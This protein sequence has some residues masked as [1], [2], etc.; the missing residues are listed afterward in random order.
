MGLKNRMICLF[1]AAGLVPIV[2]IG[3]L[4]SVI[5]TNGLMDTSYGQLVSMRGIK[6]VQIENFFAERKGDM[7][8]LVET[9]GT[10][11]QEAMNKLR[12]IRTI[13]KNQIEGFFNER[14]G[15]VAVLAKSGDVGRI[16]RA[17]QQYQVDTGVTAS[18]TYDVSTAA[19]KSLWRNN[20]KFLNYYVEAYGYYDMFI[21]SPQ[22]HVMYTTAKESDLGTNLRYGQLKD[23]GLAQLWKKVVETDKVAI[24]D[25]EPYAPSNNEPA[26][27]IGAPIKSGGRIVGVVALQ[28]SL[29]AINSIM[30]ERTGLGETGET[31]LVGSDFLMRSDSFLDP[32]HHTVKASFADPVKGKADTEAVQF[33]LSGK[34]GEDVI[35]DYNG[36]PVL[37][38]F[39]PVNVPGLK[40]AVLS[41]IDV[42]EAFSP[43]S[44]EGEEFFKKYQELYDYY[45]LFLINPNGYVF[46]TA[47]R[48]P[49]YQ[50]NMVDGKYS[51]SNLG[52]LTRDV[53][54]SKQFGFADFAPYAPSKGAPA[55]FIAQP[56][57]HDGETE[58]V[59]ALQLSLA[60]ING[61]MQQ[62]EGMG[63]TGETYLV[64]PDKLMRSDSFLDPSGHTVEASFAG[65]VQNNGVD[66]EAARDALSGETDTK[67]IIDYNGNPVLSAFTPLNVF[68]TT[69]VLI[70]EIDE[71]EVEA[72]VNRLQWLIGFIA[73]VMV[74]G[75]VAIALI[76]SSRLLK[77]L[78]NEPE[79]IAEIATQVSNGDLDIE[80]RDDGKEIV[81]VYKTMKIMAEK[82]RDVVTEVRK[83]S[84]NMASGSEELSSSSQALSQGATEQ[85]ASVEEVSSSV[86]EM[87]SSIRQNADNSR[88]TEQIAGQASS[89]ASQGGEAVGQTVKAMKQIAE[90]ISVI[91]EI[92]RQTNLLALNA[93]IEA[94][95][96]GEH[97]K[98]FAVVAAEVRKLAEKS[99]EAASEI[100]E[101]SASS[102]DVAEKAGEL[103]GKMVPDIQKTSELIHEISAA[104]NEQDTGATQI[105]SAIQQLDGVIQQNASGSEEVASTAEELSSQAMQLMQSISFFKVN[106][107]T[108]YTSN[109]QAFRTPAAPLPGTDEEWDEEA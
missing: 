43:K 53:L 86:E 88:K 98:G 81:G 8:V 104:S 54:K 38:A 27:F 39:A 48:E 22:G 82:L 94:A 72:P 14:F 91:E 73:L 77:Q 5:S 21:I 108:I 61:I 57:I 40:W 11:R 75:V 64:G 6:K 79:V 36:N 109:V 55:A 52:K 37:S 95:R 20:S 2:L 96:A 18:G 90:K 56:V 66:T 100:S 1:L 74:A 50:T 29:D 69:W 59:I 3:V 99:G 31:Y 106:L 62:R 92:A 24:Q 71:A 46:Y 32:K 47:T 85:A 78:G 19:Y 49:D 84:E 33:A 4:A 60:A 10:L 97:G 12:A 44:V 16:L 17:L 35:I 70:A 67:V 76:V 80:F 45:D 51:S 25:F 87:A 83:A 68:G 28:I 34:T 103:L 89:D 58:I 101:L 102:V 107:G 30:T 65:N 41:E 63:E 42:A 9:V 7:G 23:S 105:S 93:A 15:D 13:K 26:S